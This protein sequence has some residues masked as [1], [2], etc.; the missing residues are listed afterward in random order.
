MIIKCKGLTLTL[1][2]PSKTPP[3]AG[4]FVCSGTCEVTH[5]TPAWEFMVAELEMGNA[6]DQ[7][8]RKHR[9]GDYRKKPQ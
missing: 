9:L 3:P 5:T 8:A 4:P 6:L 1:G 2:S 7:H